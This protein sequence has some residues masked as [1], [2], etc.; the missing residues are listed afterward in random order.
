MKEKTRH[1]V[2]GGFV[3]GSLALA[4]AAILLFGSGRYFR[5]QFRAVLYFEGSVKGLNVGSAVVFRGVQVGV[6]TDI[7]LKADLDEMMF[8]IPVVV[9]FEDKKVDLTFKGKNWEHNIKRLVAGGL[10]AQLQLQSLVT[11]QLMIALDIYENEPL[12]L[13][14]GDI[15]YPQIPTIPTAFQQITQTV[16]NLPLQQIINDIASVIANIEKMLNSS[17]IQETFGHLR[18]SA[19]EIGEIMEKLDQQINPV[20]TQFTKTL[21]SFQTTAERARI[22][23]DRISDTTRVTVDAYGTMAKNLDRNLHTLT[24]DLKKTLSEFQKLARHIDESTVPLSAHIQDTLTAAKDA[25]VQG[26][27]VMSG[28]SNLLSEDAPVVYEF[29]QT[30]KEISAMAKSIRLLADYLKRHPESLI[31]GKSM[32][33]GR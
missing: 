18:K 26:K 25:M 30:L 20:L 9:E 23:V 14:K 3:V 10:R 2:I 13:V 27:T 17:E 19:S 7:I 31:Q 33:G 22:Q 4:V 12:N 6:V 11:G 21:E 8:H 28:A 29:D 24:D 1:A 5:D 16:K 15:S 32:K